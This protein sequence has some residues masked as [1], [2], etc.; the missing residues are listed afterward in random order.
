MEEADPMSFDDPEP[1]NPS[2]AAAIMAPGAHQP[3]LRKSLRAAGDRLVVILFYEDECEDCEAMRMLYEEFVVA[4]PTVLFLEA[5]V[6]S[7]M[8]TVNHLR[9]KFLPTFVAYRNHLEVG[10][11]VTTQVDD[12]EEFI[13]HNTVK[14]PKYDPSELM[15]RS[16]RSRI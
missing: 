9:L 13:K 11:V 4:Y 5:N 14:I 16:S 8:E 6:K 15:D 1:S 10:R 2:V 7:N 12:V 3:D